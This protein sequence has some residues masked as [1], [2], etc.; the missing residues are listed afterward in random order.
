MLFMVYV[1]CMHYIYMCCIYVCVMCVLCLCAYAR[2]AG[3]TVCMESRWAGRDFLVGWLWAH[4]GGEAGSGHHLCGPR[5][6]PS[7]QA[8]LPWAPGGMGGAQWQ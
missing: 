8:T 7:L 3:V 2:T 6:G 1:C 5:G 4:W